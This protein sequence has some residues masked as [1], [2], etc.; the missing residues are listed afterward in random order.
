LLFILMMR[1]IPIISI[2][3]VREGTLLQQ[4]ATLLRLRA[5]A[6]AKPR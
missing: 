2:W 3:D 5:P 4:E 6:I 1:L